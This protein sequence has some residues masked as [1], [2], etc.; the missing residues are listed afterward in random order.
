MDR[1]RAAG[2]DNPCT[3]LEDGVGKYV[4]GF[5]KTDDTYR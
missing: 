2:Y 3:P 1:L 4:T 5:L